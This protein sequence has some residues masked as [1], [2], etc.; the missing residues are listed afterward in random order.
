MAC[1]SIEINRGYGIKE[2][3]EDI[4]KFMIRTGVE[5]KDTVFLFTDTQIIEETML[6]DLNN[7]L[8]TGEVSNLFPQDETDKIV[9][10]MM[11]VCKEAG[12]IETRDNC[13]AYFVSRVRDKLHIVLCMSPVGDSLRVRCRQFPSLINCTTI[14]WFHGWPTSALVSVAER[15][16]DNLE[17]PSDAVRKSMVQMCGYVHRSIEI[18]SVQFFNELRRKLYTTPK[19]YLDLINLYMSMLKGLQDV[20]DVKSDRMKVGVQKLFETNAIVDTLRNDLIKLEPVL[21]TKSAEA[22]V[23]LE[24]VSKDTAEANIVADQ[25]ADACAQ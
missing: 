20:V 23:L 13:L 7:V 5:G 12:I 3:R 22:E 15:F 18:K 16:L 17:L 1:L 14:D 6:E 4:K 10:D 9:S 24:Q 21:K 25:V 19:S 8:N 11:P 2:F